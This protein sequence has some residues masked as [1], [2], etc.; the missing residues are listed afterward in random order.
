MT[1]SASARFL[2][3]RDTFRKIRYTVRRE[4]A[5]IDQ[6]LNV[7][8][9]GIGASSLPFNF[10]PKEPVLQ[11]SDAVFGRLERAAKAA[12]QEPH[13]SGIMSLAMKPVGSLL[14][15]SLFTSNSGTQVDFVTVLYHYT[16]YL[17]S[18][19]P[20]ANFYVSEHAVEFARQSLRSRHS[21]L[22]SEVIGAGSANERSSAETD[23]KKVRLAAALAC[24]FDAARPIRRLDPVQA[25]NAP[26][27]QLTDSPNQFCAIAIGLATAVASTRPSAVTARASE[28]LDITRL[29]TDAR[30]KGFS[31]AIRS[32]HPDQR[33]AGEFRR[34]IPYL[35]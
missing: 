18:G 16:R 7:I 24:E 22:I 3:T 26:S 8:G 10:L 23:E 2:Q 5:L 27:Q 32:D 1:K 9:S 14:S 17:L 21:I 15:N 25:M 11:I 19:L 13:A 12:L 35:P 31:A 6:T 4:A 33:L 28:I 29:V 20:V 34:V 30:F